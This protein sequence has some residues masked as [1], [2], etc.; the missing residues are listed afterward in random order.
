MGLLLETS[1]NKNEEEEEKEEEVSLGQPQG[2]ETRE[3]ETGRSV[4]PLREGFVTLEDSSP[5][6]D[7]GPRRSATTSASL[8]HTRSARAAN[9]LRRRRR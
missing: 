1:S 7:Q 9:R 5:H 8:A 4:A 2:E 6:S 3:S